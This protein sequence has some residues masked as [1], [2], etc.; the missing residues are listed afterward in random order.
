MARHEVERAASPYVGHRPPTPRPPTRRPWALLAG[1]VVGLGAIVGLGFALLHVGDDGGPSL[2]GP[3]LRARLLAER[4]VSLANTRPSWPADPLAERLPPDAALLVL[5]EHGR[6]LG[7]HDIL[8]RCLRATP[9]D[10]YIL[11]RC[12]SATHVLVVREVFPCRRG[13]DGRWPYDVDAF[14]FDLED[15]ALLGGLT[16]KGWFA[17]DCDKRRDDTVDEIV[18]GIGGHVIDA[19]RR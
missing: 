3:S 11:P 13:H 17:T 6:D 9:A 16:W 5:D 4:A 8:W 18:A 7:T 19:H 12:T 15:G 2:R 10:E 14:V 1:V